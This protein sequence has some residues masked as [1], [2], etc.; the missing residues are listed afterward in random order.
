[1]TWAA[2]CAQKR[3]YHSA[4]MARNDPRRRCVAFSKSDFDSWSLLISVHGAR[5]DAASATQ[6]PGHRRSVR[7]VPLGTRIG[8]VAT[9]AIERRGAVIR[10]VLRIGDSS[11]P[12]LV[13]AVPSP[14]GGCTVVR[15][16]SSAAADIKAYYFCH[17]RPLTL[18]HS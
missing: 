4:T 9:I 14:T 12:P 6:Q 18:I 15:N 17:I 16:R 13:P 2:N 11:A 8:T 3:R 5:D 7:H 1:M 10:S